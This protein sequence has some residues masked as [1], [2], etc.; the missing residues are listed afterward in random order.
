MITYKR[1]TTIEQIIIN[2]KKIALSKMKE[3]VKGVSGPCGHCALCGC[4]VKCNKSMVQWV[5]QIMGKTK[6]FPF[7]QK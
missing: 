3:H 5:S 2:Y 6:T 4:C 7:N 1:P